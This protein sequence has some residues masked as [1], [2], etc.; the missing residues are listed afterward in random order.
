M[1]TEHRLAPASTA[2]A[3]TCTPTRSSL[4]NLFVVGAAALIAAVVSAAVTWSVADD[5][6]PARRPAATATVTTPATGIDT[7]AVTRDLVERGLV[8]AQALEP[9]DAPAPLIDTAAVT[10]D[11]VERGLVPPQSLTDD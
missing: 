5:G 8:P 2:G 7:S 4:P 3:V 9:A 1:H 10:R 6:T 11:L